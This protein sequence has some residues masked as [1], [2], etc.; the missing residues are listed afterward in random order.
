MIITIHQFWQPDVSVPGYL[1][2]YSRP[3][4]VCSFMNLRATSC[5][6]KLLMGRA[7]QKMQGLQAALQ[8]PDVDALLT[9][10]D[11]L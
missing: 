5:D 8:P 9:L 4:R 11:N 10:H 1:S 6:A 7:N 2:L 3:M